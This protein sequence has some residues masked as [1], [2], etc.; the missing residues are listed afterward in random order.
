MNLSKLFFWRKDKKPTVSGLDQK[1]LK[2]VRSHFFPNFAQ[3]KYL[4]RFLTKFEK[5]I[6][7]L[8]TLMITCALVAFVV[9][10][11]IKNNTI[12]PASGGDYSEGLIGQPTFINPVFSS[13]NDVDADITYLIYSGLFKYDNNQNLIP[14]LAS[15]YEVSTDGKVYSINLRQNIHWSDGENFT[16]DDVIF[17]F[18]TIENPEVNSPLYPA[19]QGVQVEKTSDYSVRITL[20]NAYAPFLSSLTVGMLPQHIWSDIPASSIKLAQQNLQPIGTGPWMFNKL[21]KDSNGNIQDYVLEHNKYYYQKQPYLKTITFK[22]YTDYTQA[23]SAIKSQDIMALSFVPK[24]LA[25]KIGNKNFEPYNLQLPQYTAL[26]FN[27]NLDEDLKTDN[28]RTAL[29]LAIN[30]DKVNSD[31][32]GGKGEVI[33]TPILRGQVGYTNKIQ[34]TVFDVDQANTLLDK[35]W[36]RIQPEDYYK[37]EYAALLKSRQPEIDAIKVSTTTVDATTSIEQI[38]TEVGD[39]A[40]QKMDSDQA[41][42]RKDKNDNILTI[43]ITTADTPEYH[44]AAE[45]VA[46]MWRE[47]GVQTKIE[48]VDSHEIARTNIKERHYQVLLYGEIVGGD[49]DPFPF[50]H[51]SQVDYPGLNLALYSSRSADKILEEARSTPDNSKRASLYAD[52]Q[53]TLIKDVPAIFLY[54]PSYIFSVSKEVQGINL[55]KIV[56][57][58]DRYN[59]LSNWY[60][61]T[62]RQ[63]KFR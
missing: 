14:D 46:K 21:I 48:Y 59:D 30:K 5:K 4:P 13:T 24:D 22:F 39:A 47:I 18:E 26:F 32:T 55:D 43:T 29:A 42:Y 52:F 10:L 27:Q 20:K 19:F 8:M 2:R 35:T 45:S 6:I 51:S 3:L 1:L 38:Q 33:N 40:R 28:L 34:P 62:T 36:K 17:T 23:A 60:I 44:L 41:F 56:S 25:E 61:K 57:P 7:G 50:W 16:A 37:L 31:T 58:S 54:T 12:V 15:D 63:W 9:L 53:N 49:P 11:F